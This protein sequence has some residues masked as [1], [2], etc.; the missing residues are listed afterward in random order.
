MQLLKDAG[1]EDTSMAAAQ[2][3]VDS[4]DMSN[5]GEVDWTE[6]KSAVDHAAEPVSSRI[7]PI[8]GSLLLNFTGTTRI[9]RKI[10]K[11]N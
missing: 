7:Y 9:E 2:A 8:S 1:A 6:F 4:M 11:I 3:T 5:T 10:W